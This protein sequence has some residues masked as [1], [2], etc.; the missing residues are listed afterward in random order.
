MK[1]IWFLITLVVLLA[2]MLAACSGSAPT[3]EPQPAAAPA[4][5][6]A[7]APA[8]PVEEEMAEEEEAA[9][10]VEEEMAEE[11]EVAV[12]AAGLGAVCPNPVVIQTD[13]FPEAEHGALYEMIGDDYEVDTERKLVRGSLVASGQD[14]GIDIEVRTGGPAIG[15]QNPNTQM[16]VETDILLGY[17]SS[18]EAVLGAADTPTLAVVAP[19]EKNPQIIM[20]DPETYP[21]VE[22]IADLGETGAT[23]QVF[24]GGTFIDVFVNEGILSADQ[25]DPSYDGSP[26]RWVAENGAIAQQGF[27][28]AEPY[29]YENEIE[30]WA[31]PVAFQLIHDAGLEIYSQAL[32]IRAGELEEH[33]P[34]LEQL[35]PVIQ[36]AVV[37]YVASP[38]RANAIIIDA[39]AQYQDFWVYDADLAEFSVSKQLELGLVGNGP[40][41]IVGNME[42]ARVQGVIDKM[43]AAGMDIVDG[44]QA[45]DISTNEFIDESIG[46]P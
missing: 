13:W 14:T 11:E 36:Q 6:Q 35:V 32:A 40:D 38:D 41:G 15:F 8:A 16:Y 31:R 29:V 2:L 12:E 22:S 46:L 19:L 24:A 3:A 1:R 37:D 7:G 5:E 30:E 9:A 39:V 33:R 45:S 20:W 43:V 27:A 42:P 17:V 26:A 18:D 23:I 25:I 44:L 34:C 21:D 4:E 10:P 28:S